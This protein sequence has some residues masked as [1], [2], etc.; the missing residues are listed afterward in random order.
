MTNK[1]FQ[2]LRQDVFR[3]NPGQIF[4]NNYHTMSQI[5]IAMIDGKGLNDILELNNVNL[6]GTEKSISELMNN[7]PDSAQP[8]KYESDTTGSGSA[9]EQ[10]I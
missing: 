4:K 2:Y 8:G 6:R 10:D 1:L 3:N 7:L 5:R 9:P